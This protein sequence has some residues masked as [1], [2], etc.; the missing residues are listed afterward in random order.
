MTTFGY[1]RVSSD[2]QSLE[3]QVEALKAAGC[4]MIRSE[5]VSGASREG[6]AELKILLDFIRAGDTLL[7]C[8]LDRLARNTVDMLSIIGELGDKGVGF[9]S[10]AEP[11]ADTTSPA[12]KLM[13][14]VMSG[15]AAFERERLKERQREGID[16]VKRNGEISEKTGRYKYAGPPIKHDAAKIREMRASGMGPAAIARELG[17]SQMTVFRALKVEGAAS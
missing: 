15:V 6:R 5:K 9:K 14:T 10:L 16:R 7:V 2:E 3:V 17:C 1:A 4:D 11:W 13:L 12:G 8:K